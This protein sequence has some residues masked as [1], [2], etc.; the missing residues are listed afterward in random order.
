MFRKLCCYYISQLSGENAEIEDCECFKGGSHT[1]KEK[2]PR[3]RAENNPFLALSAL[4]ISLC[5]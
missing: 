1:I 5:T 2:K 3:Y 4:L